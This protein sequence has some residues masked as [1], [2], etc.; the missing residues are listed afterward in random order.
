MV[1]D[2]AI[3]KNETLQKIEQHQKL[4]RTANRIQLPGRD[5]HVLLL[6]NI[7]YI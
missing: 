1:K 3:Y 6:I 5:K 4:S 2:F 7:H